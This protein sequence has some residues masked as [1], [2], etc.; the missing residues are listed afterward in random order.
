MAHVL[1]ITDLESVRRT[2]SAILSTSMTPA[3]L[4]DGEEPCQ[5]PEFVMLDLQKTRGPLTERV[6]QAA[7]VFSGC[8][9]VLF[10]SGGLSPGVIG[11][12]LEAGAI[13]CI[14]GRPGT[15][16]W[17]RILTSLLTNLLRFRYKTAPAQTDAGEGV[18]PESVLWRLR[19][20]AETARSI[21]GRRGL[22]EA[23]SRIQNAADANDGTLGSS[24]VEASQ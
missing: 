12:L 8:P 9:L 10:D 14:P 6:A 2:V 7:S 4:L 18:G 22:E 23:G 19:K 5:V 17:A 15:D 24:N 21:V 20:I 1:L 3:V 16:E 11:P 13:S